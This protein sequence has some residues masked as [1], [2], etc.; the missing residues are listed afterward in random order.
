[1]PGEFRASTL[2]ASLSDDIAGRL[3]RGAYNDTIL[4]G[5]SR[6]NLDQVLSESNLFYCDIAE[7]ARVLSTGA[8]W[9]DPFY[10]DWPYWYCTLNSD[11][12]S[13]LRALYS[14]ASQL[15]NHSNMHNQQY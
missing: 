13:D 9:L 15:R 7:E 5:S 6:T 11:S 3:G 12:S 1:M 2:H 4:G 10:E 8:D 14:I